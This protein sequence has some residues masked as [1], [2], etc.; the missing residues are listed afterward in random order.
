[1]T[2][3][4]QRHVEER[5]RREADEAAIREAERQAEEFAIQAEEKRRKEKAQTQQFI[6][7]SSIAPPEL[8]RHAQEAIEHAKSQEERT[9]RA[10]ANLCRITAA[11]GPD[12]LAS[13][14]DAFRKRQDDENKALRDTGKVTEVTVQNA[15]SIIAAWDIARLGSFAEQWQTFTL[16]GLQLEQIRK[17]LKALQNADPTRF[18]PGLDF[19]RTLALGV[20]GPFK[21]RKEHAKEARCLAKIF[22]QFPRHWRY[23][24]AIKDELSISEIYKMRTR[25]MIRT[26]DREDCCFVCD[27]VMIR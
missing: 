17:R 4:H 3:K 6:L 15:A 26:C 8:K 18:P 12:L 23:F 20:D 7:A 13:I 24:P 11:N 9:Q 22:K 27:S 21:M 5:K 2:E 19:D 16:I 1:M 14:S 10:I 25:V